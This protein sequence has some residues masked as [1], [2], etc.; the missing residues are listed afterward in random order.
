MASR[1]EILLKLGLDTSAFRTGLDGMKATAKTAGAAIGSTLVAPIGAAIAATFSVNALRNVFNFADAIADTADTLGISTDY[2]QGFERLAATTGS[3]AEKAG[4]SLGFL[5]RK[6]ADA[7]SGT[8]SA[9]E[10]FERYNISMINVD[11]TARTVEQVVGDIAQRMADAKDPTDRLKMAFDLLGK[12]GTTLVNGLS[13]GKEA[14]SKFVESAPKLS[15]QEI[16]TI[17]EAGEEVESA[18]VTSKTFF[19][20]GLARF[21][22]GSKVMINAMEARK[23]GYL[24]DYVRQTLSGDAGVARAGDTKGKPMVEERYLQAR[25]LMYQEAEMRNKKITD[26]LERNK[27]EL[28]MV[29]ESLS[30]TGIVVRQIVNSK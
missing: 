10:D 25:A 13:Q 17:Q 29:N 9:I 18:I 14:V 23:R 5:S 22:R 15:E 7:R 24:D 2:L 28:K 30:R 20:K 6:I 16:R 1:E 8:V 4:Q 26:E 21:L 12:S 19:T 11:G 3:S 27:A